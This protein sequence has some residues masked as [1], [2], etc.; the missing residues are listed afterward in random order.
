MAAVSAKWA[1][2]VSFSRRRVVLRYKGQYF[3]LVRFSFVC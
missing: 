2:S 1:M 3:L